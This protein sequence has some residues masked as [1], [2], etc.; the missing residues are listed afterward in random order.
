MAESLGMQK[1]FKIRPKIKPSANNIKLTIK[2]DCSNYSS[3]LSDADWYYNGYIVS[4][5][6]INGCENYKPNTL[7]GDA[8]LYLCKNPRK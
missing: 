4:K 5:G 6:G 7:T 8:A 3:C 2:V 1:M